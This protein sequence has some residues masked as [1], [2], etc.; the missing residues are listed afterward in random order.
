MRSVDGSTRV[1]GV[2]G[3]PVEHTASPAMHNAAFETLGLNWIYVAFR[4][5]PERL[6]TA[7]RGTA[8]LGM[9]G[10]NL[11]VPLKEAALA[12]VDR[13]DPGARILGA[14]NTVVVDEGGELIGH[15]TDG[16]GFVRAVREDFGLELKGRRMAVVGVG[17][18]GRAVALQ[19]ALEGVARLVL[20]NRSMQRAESVAG[21]VRALRGDVEVEV[22]PL[23]ALGV[24]NALEGIDLAVNGTSLGLREDDPSPI[25][26]IAL[27]EGLCV[28]DLVYRPAPTP[29]EREASKR[30]VR[31]A[32]GLGMLL[33][34]GA[35][36]FELWTGMEPP[37]APMRD[38]LRRTVSG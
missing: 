19:S 12:I 23:D 8:A 36:A 4:V 26:A 2:F 33:H 7:L 10:V 29:L 28:Y 27:H 25:P 31:A 18:A 3:D 21:A 35:L 20:F 37:L 6:E 17:G 5:P 30:G 38:A 14:V 9:P 15:N 22:R 13:L 24:A 1:V 11:T 34:Q 32:N 16:P